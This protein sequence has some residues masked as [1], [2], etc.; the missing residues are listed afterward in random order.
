MDQ[1]AGGSVLHEPQPTAV[2]MVYVELNSCFG[3]IP[4]WWIHLSGIVLLKAPDH[5][6]TTVIVQKPIQTVT[7][8][9]SLSKFQPHFNRLSPTV[10]QT[11][12]SK[13]KTKASA[14]QK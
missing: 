4:S 9:S 14:Q 10:S 8:S 13:T 12:F 3:S 5:T 11:S 7:H 2:E 1:P 6:R